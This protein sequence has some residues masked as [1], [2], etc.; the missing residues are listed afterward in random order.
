MAVNREYKATLFT[1]LFSEPGKLRELYNALA[2]TDYGEEIPIEINTLENV[3][4]V[5]LRNDISFTIDNKH[6]VLLEHQSTINAN[7]PLR[8]LLYIARLFE[9]ITDERAIYHEKLLGLPTPEFIVLYNGVN[10]FP[11]EKT[12]KLSDAYK[13]TEKSIDK[14]RNL[15]LTVR[16]VN[17]NPGYNNNLLKKCKTLNG[18]SSFIERVRSNQKRGNNLQ[19]AMKEAISWGMSQDVL[20]AFF[21]EHGTE[22]RNMIQ[23]TK[24]NINIAKEVWQEEAR[25]D[26]IEEFQAV[27]AEKDAEIADK[28]IEIA[29]NIAEIANKE[30]EIVE[31]D[32]EIAR[33]EALVAQLQSQN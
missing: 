11:A 21:I 26:A 30:A 22:I 6:V 1:E 29:D 18:Y 9:K 10:P 7:M 33:L 8:C 17:I 24:F 31:K 4:F 15:E 12:L 28:D 32:T 27:L 19:D 23:G 13:G 2:D 5:D 16:V 20:S 14:F 3:F 25:E